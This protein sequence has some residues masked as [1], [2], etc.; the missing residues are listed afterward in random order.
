[1]RLVSRL[2]TVRGVKIELVW[3]IDDPHWLERQVRG[4]GSLSVSR[5]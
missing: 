1:V 4:E 5:F 2:A 3:R